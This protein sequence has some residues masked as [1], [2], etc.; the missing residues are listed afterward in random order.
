M[1]CLNDVLF[2][3]F[4]PMADVL[5]VIFA[6]MT[7]VLFGTFSLMA[8]VL[9]AGS[10]SV[11]VHILYSAAHESTVHFEGFHKRSIPERHSS[12]DISTDISRRPA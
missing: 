2:G 12:R 6:L 4:T 3:T 8:D 11:G 9:F 5:F 7:D 10:D 1:V